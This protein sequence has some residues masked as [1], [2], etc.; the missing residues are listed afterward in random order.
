MSAAP[1]PTAPE[2]TGST[3]IIDADAA[4]AYRIALEKSLAA[5]T[6]TGLTEVW[7]DPDGNIAQVVAF[8]VDA[9]AA[10]Q[11]D[12]IADTA[13]ELAGDAMMPNVLLSEL[14]ALEA[15]AA[16]DVGSVSSQKAGSFTV[17]NHVDDSKYISVYT[18]DDQGRIAKAEVSVDDEL[19]AVATFTYSLTDEGKAAFAKMK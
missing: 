10:V 4:A 14:E 13:T 6:A 3:N 8:D 9:Q 11:H 12:I 1:V 17:L 19:S 16:T 18:I 5:Q 2:P 7:R 15:N